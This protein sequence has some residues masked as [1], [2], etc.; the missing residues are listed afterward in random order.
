MTTLL[1]V[2]LLAQAPVLSADGRFDELAATL[3]AGAAGTGLM[4]W[5]FFTASPLAVYT[6]ALPAVFSIVAFEVSH[7]LTP[8]ASSAKRLSPSAVPWIGSAVIGGAAV[9]RF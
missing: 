9:A 3:V 4:A 2:A 1:L 8:H 7:V 6:L 5:A